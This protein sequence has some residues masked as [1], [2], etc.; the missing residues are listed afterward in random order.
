MYRELN[1]KPA[2]AEFSIRGSRNAMLSYWDTNFLC[3]FATESY[4]SWFGKTYDELIGKMTVT[5]LFG[6]LNQKEHQHI[7]AALQG[8]VQVYQT[9]FHSYTGEPKK[10]QVTCYPDMHNNAVQ[11][12]FLHM[13]DITG[14]NN[15]VSDF[16]AEYF[17]T[18]S[19]QILEEVIQSL[20]KNLLKS[21][22][23]ISGLAKKHFISESKLKRDFK[24]T[25]NTSL[26][27]YYRQLQMEFAESLLK[28][29]KCSKKQVAMIL[30]FSNPSN[31]S[32]CYNKYLKETES[33]RQ[34]E[35]LQKEN[36]ERYLNFISE[37][38]FA[39]AMVDEEMRYIAASGKWISDYHLESV[40]FKGKTPYDI[41]PNLDIKLKDIFYECMRGNVNRCEEAHFE[42]SEGSSI[43]LKWDIRPWYKYKQEIGGVIIFVEDITSAKLAELDNKIIQEIL[44]K[45]NEITRIGTWKRNLKS[46][47]SVWS[48]VTREIL[49]VA[50]N[51][52]TDF[53]TAVQ[54][55]REGISREQVERSV[56]H[57]ITTGEPFDVEA[58]LITAKG[59]RRWVR[60]VGYPEFE[61]NECVNLKGIFQDMTN[62]RQNKCTICANRSYQKLFRKATVGM[63]LITLNGTIIDANN[64]FASFLK[65]NRNELTEKTFNSLCAPGEEPIEVQLRK[66]Q[67]TGS[68]GCKRKFMDKTAS[69]QE[70]QV[71]MILLNAHFP[72]EVLIEL[73]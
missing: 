48:N 32:S 53:E 23:G 44:T 7:K 55:Y 16:R 18:T 25:Y 29:K 5:E 41:N 6:P 13:V 43:W 67:L 59:N 46:N 66:L 21:F 19:G 12:V 31:F 11:G 52:P 28:K 50:D 60:A 33:K 63:I 36:Y 4:L 72:G 38:P 49:E 14:Q 2:G 26:F 35:E 57:S 9:D 73:R 24:A 30:N 71:Q 27:A 15:T 39:M 3:K 40:Q 20:R 22:P 69:T 68:A 51:H 8:K 34:I 37:S 56:K 10:L 42:T 62:L 1:E 47:R 17:S 65:Y 58:E 45:T 61:N 64:A 54:F 70:R